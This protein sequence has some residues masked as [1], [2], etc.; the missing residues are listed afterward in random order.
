MFVSN[1]NGLRNTKRVTTMTF[2]PIQY[3]SNC[4]NW[5]SGIVINGC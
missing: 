5:V 3:S 2:L 4:T 1:V